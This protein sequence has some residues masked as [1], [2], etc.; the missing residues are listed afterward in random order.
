M[1]V[2]KGNPKMSTPNA[3]MKEN[4]EESS[5]QPY[6]L[7]MSR[8]GRRP[9][10]Y[11]ENSCS[12][13]ELG[14]CNH[15]TSHIFGAGRRQSFLLR[16][17]A[18]KP[19]TDKPS[20]H[21]ALGSLKAVSTLLSS[22]PIYTLGK[23]VCRYKKASKTSVGL[24]GHLKTLR[25][26][27]PP[28]GRV[29][30]VAWDLF[31]YRFLLGKLAEKDHWKLLYY[32]GVYIVLYPGKGNMLCGRYTRILLPYSLLRTSNELHEDADD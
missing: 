10:V 32:N 9:A 1:E 4:I 11:A 3:F 27:P 17:G 22:S 30:D 21:I 28:G 20:S 8:H 24:Q 15:R 7:Q 19:S 29:Q 26:L 16:A 25:S 5:S 18:D 13:F 12:T 23:K 6:S 2:L 31:S 14:H